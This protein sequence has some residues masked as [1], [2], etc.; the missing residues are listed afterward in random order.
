M[1]GAKSFKFIN[2]PGVSFTDPMIKVRSDSY[3]VSYARRHTNGRRVSRLRLRA[4]VA[5][6]C[7]APSA[8]TC[9]TRQLKLYRS[10]GRIPVGTPPQLR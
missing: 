1:N 10:Y 5:V 6:F 7:A 3:P 8:A 4:S 9:H 2:A